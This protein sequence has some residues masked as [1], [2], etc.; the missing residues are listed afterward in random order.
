[1]VPLLFELLCNTHLKIG[2]VCTSRVLIAVFVNRY[3]ELYDRIQAEQLAGLPEGD[4][5]ILTRTLMTDEATF[6]RAGIF[7]QHN[8]YY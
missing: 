3:G 8:E 4:G 2:H 7:N 1:M 6:T 5:S